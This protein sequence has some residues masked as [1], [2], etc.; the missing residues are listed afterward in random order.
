DRDDMAAELGEIDRRIMHG[1]LPRAHT[2][3]IDAAFE[4]G[5]A[6]LEH[7]GRRIADARVAIALD[8]EVEQRR[9]MVGAVEGIGDGLIDRHGDRLGRRVDLVAAVNGDGLAFHTF[10]SEPCNT[11]RS[12]SRTTHSMSDSFVRKLVIQARTTGASS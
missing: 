10:T 6:A 1:R 11:S 5:E 2:E 3:R 9:A 8:L 7:G 12:I 4:R